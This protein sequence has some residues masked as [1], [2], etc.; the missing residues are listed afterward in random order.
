MTYTFYVT[1]FESERERLDRLMEDILD[2][3]EEEYE[4]QQHQVRDPWE[5]VEIKSRISDKEEN[6]ITAKA[7]QLL[8][9]QQIMYQAEVFQGEI[10]LG[11]GMKSAPLLW[12]IY[13]D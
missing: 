10:G 9:E 13:L 12:D 3:Y 7:S 1:D 4:P 5:G 6:V 8:Q 2:E 11:Q